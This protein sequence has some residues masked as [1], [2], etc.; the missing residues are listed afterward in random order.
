[1]REKDD[2]NEKSMNVYNK[3]R[4]IRE[5]EKMRRRRNEKK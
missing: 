5:T 3:E 4:G 2:K 1:M